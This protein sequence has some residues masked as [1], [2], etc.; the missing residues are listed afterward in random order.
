MHVWLSGRKQR[1]HN[2]FPKG[3]RRFKPY[4]MQLKKNYYF[5]YS[6]FIKIFIK[7][8]KFLLLN[9]N[10]YFFKISCYLFLNSKYFN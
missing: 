8:I 10:E 6:I 2:P 9:K 4:C 1:T 7:I 3:H 5:K